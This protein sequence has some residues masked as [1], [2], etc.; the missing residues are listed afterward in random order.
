[1]IKAVLFDLDGTLCNTLQDLAD[2]ANYAL[3]T[4]G[5]PTHETEKYRYFVGRGMPNLIKSILPENSRDK[6]TLSRV[7][8]CFLEY[9][10]AHYADNTASYDGID[11]LLKEL[12]DRGIK[13]AVVTNKAQQPAENVVNKLYPEGFFDAVV[14]QT[15]DMPVKPDPAMALFAAEKIGAEIHECL[16]VGDSGS[17]C[18]TGVRAGAVPVGVLWGFR[19][20]DELT[21]GGASYIIEKPSELLGLLEKI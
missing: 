11:E 10:A 2:A 4:F 5:F 12:K 16:F 9:Y 17:D 7:L 13:I 14:G 15:P 20:R 18:E 19:E 1:M 3:G 21:S 8:S 6:D